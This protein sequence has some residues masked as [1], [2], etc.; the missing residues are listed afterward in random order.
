MEKF[1][2]GNI[3]KI[4]FESNSGPYKVGL[5]KVKETNDEDYE[6]YINK[7]IGFTGDFIDLNYDSD[8]ILYGKMINH[9][10]Y[11][12]QFSASG[13]EI[14]TPT[15]KE[16]LIL[17]LSSGLFRGIGI[18]TAKKIVEKFGTNTIDIIKNNYELLTTVDSI[19][20][21]KAKMM[22]NKIIDSQSNQDAIIKL[23]SYGFSVKES[24]NLISKYGIDLMNIVSENIY[25][26]DKDVS[27]NKLDLI[28]LNTHDD[29]HP[30]R[31]KALIKY[32]IYNM[33]YES[34]DTLIQKED[35]FI[36][37]KKCFNKKFDSEMFITYVDE[38]LRENVIVEID[39]YLMLYD[40]YIAEKYIKTNIN[41]INNIREMK[42]TKEVKEYIKYYENKNKILF[43]DTQKKAI[44]GALNNNLYIITGGPGTGKTTIIKT[45]VQ[46][47]E[48]KNKINKDDIVLLAPTGRSAKKMQDSVGY[49]AYTIHKFLKW[50]KEL[51]TFQIDE[52][53]KAKEKVVIVDEAS[54]ID[55]FL[56]SS[57]LKGLRLNVKLI[58]VGDVNQLPS[59][60]PGDVLRDLLCQNNIKNTYLN[61][62]Y[63]VNEESYISD[64][65]LD[66]KNQK[67][68]NNIDDYNDFKF[69]KSSDEDIKSYLIQ[70]CNYVK[71]KK[72]SL[73]N[74]QVL[75]P[76]YK[77]V[78]GI[79]NLNILMADIFNSKNKKYQIGDKFCRIDDKVIQLVN[80]VDNN[81]YNGD[82]G[83]IKDINIINKKTIV[84]I[85]FGNNKVIYT[86][87]DFDK[88]SLAYAISI[89]KS[90]GS[91]YDHVVIILANSFVRMFYN[92]LIYTAVTR[93]KSSLTIIGSL[94]AFNTCIKTLYANNRKTYINHV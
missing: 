62:I 90:Q 26:L 34:G 58:L 85:E 77:G 80:D 57:L 6:I 79:D 22:Y 55:I 7:I 11:G 36:R 88:F 45:I 38:S 66:I 16:S 35:L 82:I 49:K 41:R 18:K 14:K 8:Y 67:E 40:F 83:Y 59:I 53:N 94:Q 70:I 19:S 39:K 42:K 31:I 47:L 71:S 92:K 27:F 12:I 52:Y 93:A 75:V 76:M 24:I 84:E 69:I 72:I 1:I 51:E 87:G 10:K 4:I 2:I 5:F 33:C 73:D 91:E 60:A 63:R 23:N 48:N 30:Y 68:F 64:I 43:D 3:K 37:M 46:I 89:H 50:N 61:K 44:I 81:V 15:D 28:F 56:F 25:M 32:N 65:A 74:F 20:L 29:N 17:Y 9:P 78:N 86:N 13:Y 54:M 21:N